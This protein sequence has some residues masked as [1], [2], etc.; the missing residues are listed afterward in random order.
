MRRQRGR[1]ICDQKAN[2]VADMAEVLSR[3]QLSEVLKQAKVKKEE[4]ELKE[5]EE[6]EKAERKAKGIVEPEP[7]TKG[8]V[9]DAEGKPIEEKRTEEKVVVER[10]KHIG[11]TG[12]GTGTEI[13]VLWS[14]LQDAEFAET[15]GENVL[16]GPLPPYVSKKVLALR[17]VQRL[18]DEEKAAKILAR[19]QEL[20]EKR[21]RKAEREASKQLHKMAM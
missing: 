18:K 6:K 7:E 20:E 19:E 4:A 21:A 12:E 3:L 17:E 11:L 8:A 15:W 10:K 5:K 1:M 14:D 9:V 16:H 2:T 13:E